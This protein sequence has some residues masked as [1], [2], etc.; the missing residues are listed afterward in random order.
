M[1]QRIGMAAGVRGALCSPTLLPVGPAAVIVALAVA[2]AA[3]CG[4]GDPPVR[5]EV[6]LSIG[7]AAPADAGVATGLA[8]ITD[9]LTREGLFRTGPDGRVESMLAERWEVAPDGTAVTVVLRRDAAFHD[10]SP[11]TAD[12]VK[13]SLDRI[14]VSPPR[15]ARNPLL[16]DIESIAVEGP[17]RLVINMTKSSAQMLLFGLGNRVEKTGPEGQ[18]IATGPFF[19][20]SRTED[21]VTLR[22][23]PHYYQGRSEIDTV[24]I[25]TYPTLRTAWAA[26]MRSEIDFLFNVSIEAREFV[27]ADSSVRVFSRDTPTPTCCCSTRAGRRSTTAG[28]VWRS[29][30]RSTARRLLRAHFEV[31]ARSHRGSGP[32][33]GSTTAWS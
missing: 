15:I 14:R 27:E 22:A 28:C 10:G 16:G 29:A 12:D 20:E 1:A 18:Q 9:Q 8:I 33:T 19:V 11:V 30:A 25:K 21:E 31:T 23:N 24:R 6:V 13:S 3:A 2:L 17:R 32:R 4:P 7:Y 26:M 5:A